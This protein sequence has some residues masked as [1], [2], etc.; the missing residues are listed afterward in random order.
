MIEINYTLSRQTDWLLQATLD[1]DV[2]S[3]LQVLCHVSERPFLIGTKN[4][5]LIQ[6]NCIVSGNTI[7]IEFN[8]TQTAIPSGIYLYDVKIVRASS[9]RTVQYGRIEIL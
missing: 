1:E 2:E 4:R 9:T 6:G 7:S 8:S 5:F 3:P